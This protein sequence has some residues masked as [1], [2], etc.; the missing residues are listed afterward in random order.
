MANIDAKHFGV[1]EFKSLYSSEEMI[2]AFWW[3]IGLSNIG[4][5]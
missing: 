2:I 4:Y 3:K 1:E 5:K